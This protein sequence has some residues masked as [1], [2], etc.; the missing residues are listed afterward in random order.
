MP[1]EITRHGGR[2]MRRSVLIVF[3]GL[4][5]CALLMGCVKKINPKPL[6]LDPLPNYIQAGEHSDLDKLYYDLWIEAEKELEEC[7]KRCDAM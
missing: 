3:G 4:L 6:N 7:V 2:T 5:S 1:K